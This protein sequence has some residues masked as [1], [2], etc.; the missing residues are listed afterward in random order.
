MIGGVNVKGLG[1][2]LSKKEKTKDSFVVVILKVAGRT[3]AIESRLEA[4]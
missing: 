3:S 1:G 2:S 4:G